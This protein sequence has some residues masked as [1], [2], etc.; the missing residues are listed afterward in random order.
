MMAF[1]SVLVPRM[2]DP[3][4]LAV[5]VIGGF[6]MRSWLHVLLA[7]AVEAVIVEFLLTYG[8]SSR[9]FG[10]GI[11]PGY[12]AALFQCSLVYRVMKFRRDRRRRRKRP[13]V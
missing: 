6:F 11:L 2:L 8:Q 5:A 9:R 7:A 1:L 10:P 4:G 12:L 3:F 13:R